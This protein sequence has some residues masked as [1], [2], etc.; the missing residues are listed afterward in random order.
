MGE[1]VT[2]LE[3]R[4]KVGDGTGAGEGSRTLNLHDGDVALYR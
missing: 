2:S 4:E 1:K 3:E